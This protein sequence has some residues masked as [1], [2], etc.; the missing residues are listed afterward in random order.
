MQT[1]LYNKA[2]QYQKRKRSASDSESESGRMQLALK[3]PLRENEGQYLS[4][5]SFRVL[6]KKSNE[7]LGL[8]HVSRATRTDERSSSMVTTFGSNVV[9]LIDF[10][11]RMLP[12]I[13]FTKPSMVL[14][15][16][17]VD[18]MEQVVCGSF[19]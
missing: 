2:K 12:W 9:D 16:L 1:T 11:R 13:A 18:Y 17:L 15:E 3:Q 5:H 8:S 6:K 7:M 4:D 14:Q 10:L 19:L